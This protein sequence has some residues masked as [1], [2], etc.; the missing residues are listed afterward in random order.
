MI[1]P[2]F[3]TASNQGRLGEITDGLG[4]DRPS[5]VIEAGFRSMLAEVLAADAERLDRVILLEPNGK[6]ADVIQR[7]RQE[8]AAAG[9]ID[10]TL[11]FCELS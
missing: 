10:R 7:L 1:A 8:G 6:P 11:G 5:V 9:P 3:R 4:L 2:E